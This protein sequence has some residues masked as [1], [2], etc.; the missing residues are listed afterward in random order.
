LYAIKLCSKCL[1]LGKNS[2]GKNS[3]GEGE[4]HVVPTSTPLSNINLCT[5]MLRGEW[6]RDEKLMS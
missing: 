5:E 2:N 6:V 4:A 3:I 1:G